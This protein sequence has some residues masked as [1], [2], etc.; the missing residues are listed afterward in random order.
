MKEHYSFI[1]SSNKHQSRIKLKTYNTVEDVLYLI[2]KSQRILVITGAGISTSLG[3]P[4]FRSDTGIYSILEKYGLS[5]PQE[6]FDIEVF[7]EDPSVFYSFASELFPPEKFKNLFYSPTHAFIK[8]LQDKGKLL[9]QYTQNVDNIEEVVGIKKQK[10]VQCHGSFKNAI[11]IICGHMVSGESI[12]DNILLKTVPKCLKCLNNKKN[13]RENE[14]DYEINPGVLKPNITFFG[15]KLPKSFSDRI[16]KDIYSCDLVICIGTSLKVAPVSKIINTIPSNIP[17]IYIS[18]ES[19]KHIAFDITLLSNYC[20]DIVANLCNRLDWYEF[21]DIAKLGH[22][23]AFNRMINNAKL[24][25]KRESES[26]WRLDK[27]T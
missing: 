24:T 19:V 6:V 9:V 2:Q 14:N 12:L 11:C 17:Q 3:I 20:D 25:W 15:E 5:E 18:R 23:H 1:G 16:E 22:K 10:L 27:D 26:I 8:L 7:R 13:R 4:D 21:Y